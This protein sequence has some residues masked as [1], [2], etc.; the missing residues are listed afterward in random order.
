MIR[1][2]AMDEM[3]IRTI[4][5]FMETQRDA[6]AATMKNDDPEI[7][8]S[9]ATYETACLAISTI[10]KFVCGVER[11]AQLP[12]PMQTAMA[13]MHDAICETGDYLLRAKG[14]NPEDF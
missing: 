8:K 4:S 10:A 3:I 5:V 1:V 2:N 13:R 7:A 9:Q 14:Y 11:D 6:Y 12:E